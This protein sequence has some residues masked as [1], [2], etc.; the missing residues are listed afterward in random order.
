MNLS[1]IIS[2][3]IRYL[4]HYCKYIK[5][6]FIISTLY[7]SVVQI[8]TCHLI[9]ALLYFRTTPPGN[10]PGGVVLWRNNR[11]IVFITAY[12]D[13]VKLGY[14]RAA[15]L[16]KRGFRQAEDHTVLCNPVHHMCNVLNR[17]LSTFCAKIAA[18]NAVYPKF[19]LVNQG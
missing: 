1:D 9:N 13:D 15:L 10:F 3:I 19:M 6:I 14:G 8:S 18:L 7:H 11:Q 4:A 12:K 5:L 17:A 2:V 16:D